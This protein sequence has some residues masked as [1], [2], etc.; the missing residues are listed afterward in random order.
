MKRRKR[1]RGKGNRKI[2]KWERKK[3][4]MGSTR[5]NKRKIGHLRAKRSQ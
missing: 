5:S 2:K 4:H 3:E 1:K